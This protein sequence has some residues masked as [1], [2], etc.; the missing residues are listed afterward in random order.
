VDFIHNNS[1]GKH[2]L[3][4]LND[5]EKSIRNETLSKDQILSAETACI[6]VIS[7]PKL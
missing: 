2:F 6:H 5:N 7:P 3:K 1:I 4:R